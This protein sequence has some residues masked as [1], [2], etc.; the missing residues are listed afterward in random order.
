M[1]IRKWEIALTAAFLLCLMLA[2]PIKVRADLGK[3]LTRLHVVANSDSEYD[4]ELKMKVRDSVLDAVK[5]L[6]GPSADA[7]DM[8]KRAAERTVNGEY[9]ITVSLG[10][11]WF[12]TREYDTFSLPC[13]FYEAVRVT[14]GRGEGKNFWCV[15]FPPLCA[16]ASEKELS[17]VPGITKTEKAFITEDGGV[18]VL[19]FKIVELWGKLTNNLAFFKKSS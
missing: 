12:E 9:P 5:D 11:E 2:A 8:I 7:L 13:G 19:G 15:I 17:D 3:K 1:K 10:R 14:I 4:Q 16:A 6:D 18:Y